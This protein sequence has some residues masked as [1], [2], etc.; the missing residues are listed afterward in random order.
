MRR[1]VK[2]NA[3]CYDCVVHEAYDAEFRRRDL[4]PDDIIGQLQ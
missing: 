1:Y 3:P 4:E 2:E